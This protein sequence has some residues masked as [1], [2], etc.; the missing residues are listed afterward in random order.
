MSPRMKELAARL[1]VT[2]LLAAVLAGNAVAQSDQSARRSLSVTGQGEASGP[3]DQAQIT[4]GVQTL[5]ETV[6]DASRQN[7]AIVE[8]IMQAL[9]DQGIAEEDIQTSGYNIWPEQRHDPR[10]SG[11][12]EITGYRVS[13]IVNVV[14]RD[15]EK[16]GEVLAAV[17]NAGANSVH[18]IQFMAEDTAALEERARAAAMADARARAEALAELAGVELGE[19]LTIS[20]SS[21]GSHPRPMAGRFSVEAVDV[22]PVPGVSPGQLSVNAQVHVTFAI[23]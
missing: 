20:M 21:G 22:A 10:G 6:A 1:A 19:V 8:K 23:H 14:V 9:E 16:V 18:G 17:T 4:A 3:P 2:I 7:Q 12:V 13:N 5:A 11:E 15:I